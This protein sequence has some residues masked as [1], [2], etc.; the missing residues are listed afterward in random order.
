MILLHCRRR[1]I[2]TQTQ[3]KMFDD[4]PPGGWDTRDEGRC[5]SPKRDDGWS[6]AGRWPTIL[7]SSSLTAGEAGRPPIVSMDEL[8]GARPLFFQLSTATTGVWFS[9]SLL[10]PEITRGDES[11]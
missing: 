5:H 7:K 10:E 6:G 11:S 3:P 4:L 1:Q 2:G 9:G 8:D